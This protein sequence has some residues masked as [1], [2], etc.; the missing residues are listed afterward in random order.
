MVKRNIYGKVNNI[1]VCTKYILKRKRLVNMK[2][3]GY[4]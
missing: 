4:T 2:C 3:I 1:M